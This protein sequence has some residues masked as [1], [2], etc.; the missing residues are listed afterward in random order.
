MKTLT[1]SY[2]TARPEPRLDWFTESLERCVAQELGGKWAGIDVIV[3]DALRNTRVNTIRLPC[4]VQHVLPKPTVWQ[5][6][7]RLT[8]QDW[9]AMSN[10]RNTAICLSRSEWIAFLD[11]RSVLQ[12]GYFKALTEAMAGNYGVAGGYEKRKDMTVERGVIK[13]GGIITGNDGRI[14]HQAKFNLPNPM[15]CGGEWFF[16]ANFAMPLEWTL[17]VNGIDETCDGSSMEDVIF[18]MQLQHCGHSLK[19]DSRMKIIEDRTPGLTG[20][21]MIRR[22]KGVS[23]NDKSH[24]LLAKCGSVKRALHH[25][26]MRKV[27]LNVLAGMGFPK[28]TTPTHD[29]YDGQPLSEMTPG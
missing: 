22:D 20:T 18:G 26:D 19:F 15:S 27:R 28:A 23:P 21:P 1:I 5:G 9:W 7:S 2:I 6:A 11:D 24:A 3:V 17:E 16:G 10:A 13:N 29:W 14:E 25:W 4:P 8:K 12:L